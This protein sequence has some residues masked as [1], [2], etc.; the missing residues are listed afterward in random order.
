L[1]YTTQV[2]LNA[3][4]AAPV[5][6]VLLVDAPV[7]M[8]G[9]DSSLSVGEPMLMSGVES[10]GSA[11]AVRGQATAPSAGPLADALGVVAEEEALTASLMAGLEGSSRMSVV[12]QVELGPVVSNKSLAEGQSPSMC[13]VREGGA[14]STLALVAPKVG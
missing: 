12:G 14:V 4:H 7:G 8:S 10:L 6:S 9:L 1:V 11:P 2:L 3:S 13:P 5:Q